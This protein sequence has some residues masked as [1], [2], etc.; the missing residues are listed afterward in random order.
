MIV[1]YHHSNHSN[2]TVTKKPK[3]S[4]ASVPYARPT[5]II[6][7]VNTRKSIHVISY[8]STKMELSHFTMA[9]VIFLSSKLIPVVVI[10]IN[11]SKDLDMD[12]FSH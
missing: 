7:T 9:T 12:K 6:F 10:K 8:V 1:K 11:H 4:P 5:A 2:V 3:S